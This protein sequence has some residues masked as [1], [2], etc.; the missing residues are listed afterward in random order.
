M[1]GMIISEC[2]YAEFKI[3]KPQTK[4]FI[5]FETGRNLQGIVLLMGSFIWNKEILDIYRNSIYH[6]PIQIERN[7][8]INKV[9]DRSLQLDDFIDSSKQIVDA[10][11]IKGQE[12]I[13]SKLSAPEKIHNME[14]YIRLTIANFIVCGIVFGFIFYIDTVDIF[15]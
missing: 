9:E 11:P 3:E 2:F 8:R 13:S 6:D 1:L 5:R 15:E 10:I 7:S 4:D 12:A 14:K